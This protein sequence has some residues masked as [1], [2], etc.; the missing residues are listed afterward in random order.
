VH[1][2]GT[3]SA[4]CF[5]CGNSRNSVSFNVCGDAPVCGDID[6]AT[7]AGAIGRH[8][9]AAEKPRPAA[10]KNRAKRFAFGLPQDL[11][12]QLMFEPCA[13]RGSR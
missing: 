8:S 11:H 3:I 2:Q 12:M 5:F 13:K 6:A 4:A 7:A 1:A 9:G 10:R